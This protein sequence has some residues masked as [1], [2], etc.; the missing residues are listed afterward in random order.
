[1]I[2]GVKSS[3]RTETGTRTIILTA[4]LYYGKNGLGDSPQL[5]QEFDIERG[6][7]LKSNY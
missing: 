2:H 7:E 5:I 4:K 6:Q 3:R 1:M